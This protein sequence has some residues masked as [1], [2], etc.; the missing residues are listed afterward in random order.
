[1]LLDEAKLASGIEATLEVEEGDQKV[2]MT[3]RAA[4][5]S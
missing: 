2:S 4:S 5:E 3:L 1:M